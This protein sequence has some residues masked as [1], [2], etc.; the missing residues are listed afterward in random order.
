MRHLQLVCATANPHKLVEIQAILNEAGA[1]HGITIELLPRPAHLGDVIEDADTLE[2]NALL[3]ADAVAAAGGLPAIADDTGLEVAALD[4]APGVYSARYAGEDATYGDNCRK[5]L[6]ELAAT[7]STDRSAVFATV[8]VVRWPAPHDA[9]VSARGEC[10]GHITETEQGARG[11]GYDPVFAPEADPQRRTF[12]QMSE[13]E[14]NA[15]SH[16][17]RAFRKLVEIL[18][19][20]PEPGSGVWSADA[21]SND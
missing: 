2:G 5:L 7:G 13:D 3:K 8:A 12:A 4:G 19:Q 15:L 17:G 10:R 18:A 11:F 1:A 6:S 14:K 21:P 9:T 20:Y 16:R